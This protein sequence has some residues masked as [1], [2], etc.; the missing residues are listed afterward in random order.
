MTNLQTGS[1]NSFKGI[2][3][4]RILSKVNLLSDHELKELDILVATE[5]VKRAS[6]DLLY[7]LEHMVWTL[8]E[9]DEVH[10]V[11][12]IPMDKEYLRE[13]ADHFV[14][15]KLL[16]VEK[17]RQMMVTW[18]MVACH[19]WDAQFHEGRR[20]FIQ[21]KKEADA[22]HLIDRAKFI[23]E[24]Y[25][26]PYKSVIHARFPAR[27]PMAYLKLAFPKHNSILQGTPQG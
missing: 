2:S 10:P 19:L 9:H 6:E 7:F 17:S 22:N 27:R 11:K 25:P 8:D 20:I 18:L 5:E 14:K 26:E 15:E 24:N 1:L 23:Y 12:K 13:L 4:R 16:L 21:S 3:K